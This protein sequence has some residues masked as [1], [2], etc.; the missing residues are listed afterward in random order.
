MGKDKKDKEDRRNAPP[1]KK[2]KSSQEPLDFDALPTDIP[3]KCDKC[4][5]PLGLVDKITQNHFRRKYKD[6]YIFVFGAKH[7]QIICLHC[8]HMN[9][10]EEMALSSRFRLEHTEEGLL[11]TDGEAI[12]DPILFTDENLQDLLDVIQAL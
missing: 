2:K 4:N 3:W 7:I 5:K 12:I 9:T 11:F 8:A 6:L 1:P 10:M